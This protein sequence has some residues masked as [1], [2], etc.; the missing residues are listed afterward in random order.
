MLWLVPK[1]VRNLAEFKKNLFET[2]IY[3]LPVSILL[4]TM[5]CHGRTVR[6]GIPSSF[7]RAA[8]RSNP[9]PSAR[10]ALSRASAAASPCFSRP[11]PSQ[12]TC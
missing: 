7:R 9:R 12:V 11:K 4:M 3:R 6:V 5:P 8:M 2:A 1:P 10:S